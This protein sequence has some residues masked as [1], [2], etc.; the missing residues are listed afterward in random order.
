MTRW[1]AAAFCL[2]FFIVAL[3]LESKAQDSSSVHW[4]Y[5]AYFGT[6]WYSVAGDRDVFVFRITPEWEFSEPS[7]ENGV[8]K[9]GWYLKTPVVTGLDQFDIDDIPEAVDLDNIAFLSA[10]AVLELEVP[11]NEMWSLRPY[12][13]VGYGAALNDSESAWTYWA[14][15]KSRVNLHS[16]E[17]SSWSLVNNVGYVGYTPNNGPSDSFW[18]AM[19]GI[20]VSH[21]FGSKSADG[22]SPWLFHWNA[23]YT[24][25]GSDIFFSRAPGVN[26]NVSDQWEVGVAFG[27]KTEPIKIWFVNLDR[28][29]LGYRES[30]DGSLTGITFIFRSAFTR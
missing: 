2:S 3:P 20:E 30:S 4:A 17:R 12:A 26:Q 6:G 13:S 21:P 11:V 27:K 1:T 14:G 19:A 10:N 25:F 7:L 22:E 16:G 9:P 5:S 8:R 15:V 29:G 23:G 24:Y 28:I 18:P